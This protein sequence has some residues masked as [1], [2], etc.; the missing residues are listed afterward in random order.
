MIANHFKYYQLIE[1]VKITRIVAK[2]NRLN[3]SQANL[4]VNELTA[5]MIFFKGYADLL[6]IMYSK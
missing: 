6:N 1:A 4:T 3:Q 2:K 5:N